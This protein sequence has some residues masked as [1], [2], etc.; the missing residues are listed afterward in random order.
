MSFLVISNMRQTNFEM[1]PPPERGKKNFHKPLLPGCG[2][3]LNYKPKKYDPDYVGDL[4][5]NALSEMEISRGLVGY[6]TT[7]Q[8]TAVNFQATEWILYSLSTL[9][10]REIRMLQFMNSVTDKPEWFI[11]VH[12]PFAVIQYRLTSS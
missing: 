11:Q 7:V 9:T 1:T 3:P 4:F 12:G 8:A 6:V 2:R 5:A 10:V